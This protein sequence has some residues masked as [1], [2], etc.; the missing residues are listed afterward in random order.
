MAVTSFKDRF[1]ELMVFK[2]IFGFL[3]SSGTLKSLS[4]NELEEWC[5]RFAETFSLHILCDVEVYDLISELK[6]VGFTLPDDRDICY[7]DF[8]H[9]KRSWLLS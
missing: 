9:V 6:I 2:D 8:E 4:D 7:G 1:R 3:L 5:T